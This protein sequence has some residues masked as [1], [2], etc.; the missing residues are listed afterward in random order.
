MIHGD[1]LNTWGCLAIDEIT[2]NQQRPTK[3]NANEGEKEN[4]M[5]T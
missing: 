5:K 2:Y 4:K 3:C 1:P